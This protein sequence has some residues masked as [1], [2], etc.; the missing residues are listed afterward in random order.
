MKDSIWIFIFLYMAPI[1]KKVL[2]MLIINLVILLLMIPLKK[3]LKIF[4]NRYTK[5]IIKYNN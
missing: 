4:E 1:N 5:Y 2:I 3:E